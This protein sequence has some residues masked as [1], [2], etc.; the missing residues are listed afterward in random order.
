MILRKKT[1]IREG[2]RLGTR[3]RSSPL[4]SPDCFFPL[5]TLELPRFRSI[6][7]G[8]F[9]AFALL[10][11]SP[12]NGQSKPCAV[13]A[14][15][16]CGE[17][18]VALTEAQA[19]VAEAARNGALWTTASESLQQAHAAYTRSDFA[20]ATRAAKRATALAKLGIAQKSYQPFPKP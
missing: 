14:A 5:F 4:I 1:I 13:D 15:P 6:A 17:A 20:T 11:A 12:A 18:L 7:N 10:V 8:I 16:G 3:K 19:A 9:V 2:C